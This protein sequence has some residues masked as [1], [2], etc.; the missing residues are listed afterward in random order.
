MKIHLVNK[1]IGQTPLQALEKLRSKKKLPKESALTYAGRLD[2]MAEG[3][4]LVLENASQKQKEKHLKLPKV[5]KTQ[6][7]LGFSSDTGDIL[8]LAKKGVVPSLEK[9]QI[10]TA[11][12][13]FQGAIKLNLPAYC[14]VP[15]KGR[16]MFMWAREGYFKHKK[17]PAREMVVTNI[18]L[19]KLTYL[20]SYK[21]LASIEKKL[22]KVKGDFRQKKI[23]KQWQKLLKGKN[24]YQVIELNIACKSG[25]YIRSIAQSLGE[26]L[27]TSGLLFALKRQKIGKF[28]LP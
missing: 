23:L 3:L 8:G 7:L 11:L 5:Y 4:L 9:W 13:K 1:K 17:T 20:S 24:K 18:S 16:P 19:S 15:F 14:S 12:K 22:R 25:T 2:P 6:I 26:K 27:K 21:V 28:H 10:T